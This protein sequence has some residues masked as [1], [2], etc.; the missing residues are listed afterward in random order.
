MDET[1]QVSELIGD[2]YDAALDPSLWPLVLGKAKGFVG[3]VAASLYSKDAVN[4]CGNMFYQNADGIDPHYRH[5]Y[6]DTYVKLD[7]TT[8]GHF[9]AELDAP[10][11]TNDIIPYQEFLETRFY[12]EWA[13]PQGLVD[14]VAAVIEKSN[15]SAALF[16]I[17]RHERDGLVDDEARR[18]MALITPHVRRAVLIGKAIDLKTAEAATFADT[19][20]GLTAGMFLVDAT[21]RIIH[22]NTTGH[23]IFREGDFLCA[24]GD[25][26]TASD[27]QIDRL[28]R[29][30]FAAAGNGDAAI[31]IKGIA[32]P[33]ISRGGEHHVAHVLPLTSGARRRA[34]I[35]TSAVAALFVQKA[36]LD[37]PSP[38]EAIA[39]AYKLTPTELRV[40]LA[41]IEVG[42]GPEVAEALG[43]STE[44]VKGHLGQLYVKTGAR[45]QADL[46]K[47]V[48][49][50]SS[51]LQS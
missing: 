30:I 46:V 35:A 22:A 51:P 36:A 29:D 39:K 34:G 10:V 2:I 25:R 27:P 50:F 17:F 37:T 3:G 16:G 7:P 42:G 5:L 32:V 45:R 11:A 12:L 14:H 21:G 8:T 9:F 31:G 40:L 28:F 47:L 48:A 44:T 13:R 49:G 38:P 1:A 33:L 26:L 18:R 15:T 6:F 4:K 19:L 23:A 43:V 20:D 24:I 41:V